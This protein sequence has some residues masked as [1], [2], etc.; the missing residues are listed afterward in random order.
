VLR[1]ICAISLF[2]TFE[3][4]MFVVVKGVF[5]Y[6]LLSLS[7]NWNCLLVYF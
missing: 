6:G 3:C 2:A 7:L 5:W 4:A 1:C